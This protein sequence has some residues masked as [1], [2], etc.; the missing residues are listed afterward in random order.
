MISL[1]WCHK[2]IWYYYI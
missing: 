2:I 1:R